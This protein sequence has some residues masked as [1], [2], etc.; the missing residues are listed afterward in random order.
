MKRVDVIIYYSFYRYLVSIEGL[1]IQDPLRIRLMSHLQMFMTQRTN[2][3][4]PVAPPPPAPPP[5]VPST[6]N[7]PHQWGYNPP[8]GYGYEDP[9][10]FNKMAQPPASS[11]TTSMTSPTNYTMT[12]TAT[13]AGVPP[14]PIG[15][16]ASVQPI[17]HHPPTTSEAVTSTSSNSPSYTNLS[18]SK[19]YR[20]WGAEMAC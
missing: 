9:L 16:T 14:A 1:D 11:T 3:T 4:T 10:Y 17:Y 20:P 12:M 15:F 18:S 5:T 7:Y 8:S 6:P 13:A 19:P 2:P